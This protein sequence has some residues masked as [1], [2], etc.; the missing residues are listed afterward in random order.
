MRPPTT[1]LGASGNMCARSVDG[2]S[3]VRVDQLR[4]YELT[5]HFVQGRFFVAME[6][7]TMLAHA[8]INYDF[9]LQVPG[10]RPKDNVFGP[11]VTPNI[12]TK[13][14]FRKRAKL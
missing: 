4:I 1:C 3:S 7:K 13:V 9:E 12:F 5:R 8:I 6:L 2:L 14:W 11:S 10:V